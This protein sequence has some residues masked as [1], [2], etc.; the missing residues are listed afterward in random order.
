MAELKTFIAQREGDRGQLEADLKSQVATLQSKIEGLEKQKTAVVVQPSAAPQI[1]HDYLPTSTPIV[2]TVPITSKTLPDA[3]VA[4][5]TS[6]NEQDL[7]VD[8]ISCK[9]CTAK[10]AELE[11]ESKEK[12][13][14]IKTL[15]AERDKAV[16]TA[17]GG[18]VFH[19]MLGVLKVAA[20]AGLG[21]GAGARV[22]R[23]GSAAI[24][25]A[26]GAIV[27][28]MIGR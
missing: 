8:A 5:L 26:S 24:G 23:P 10:S 7:A 13:A 19:R 27:C 1:I 14:E 17:K 20:C 4:Q 18:S 22:N 16:L 15:T 6:R 2:Q 25:A 21:A 12:D 28:S 11:A 9:E 3:P